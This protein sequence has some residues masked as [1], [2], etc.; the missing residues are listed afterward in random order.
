MQRRLRYGSELD[1]A[2]N[3]AVDPENSADLASSG[4]ETRVRDL[5]PDVLQ[6]AATD[7]A[8]SDA[9]Q[10][11]FGCAEEKAKLEECRRESQGR[12]RGG[13]GIVDR[14]HRVR[15]VPQDLQEEEIFERAQ[16]AARRTAR[17]SHVWREAD[18][19]VLPEDSHQAAQQGIH[20]I[21][22]DLQQGLLFEGDPE[23]SHECAHGGKTMHLRDLPQVLWQSGLSP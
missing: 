14:S 7:Q 22:R 23:D 19:R 9:M 3:R 11:S 5:W 1:S 8:S 12:S 18:V 20:G 10:V 17:L 6:K 16:D 13:Q 2:Q 4:E 15:R 21:L